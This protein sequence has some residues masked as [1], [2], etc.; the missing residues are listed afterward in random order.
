MSAPTMSNK[1]YDVTKWCVQIVFPAFGTLYFALG[2]IWGWEY[3]EAVVAT[4]TAVC[5]FLGTALGISSYNYHNSDERFDGVMVASK[6]P[7]GDLFSLELNGDPMDLVNRS[8][9]S[10]KVENPH[11]AKDVKRVR[12]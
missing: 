2:Q 9:I 7:G 5:T 8:E 12:K 1:L 11:A 6:K 10:F 3:E 4:I